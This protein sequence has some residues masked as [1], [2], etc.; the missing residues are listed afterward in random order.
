VQ[1]YYFRVVTSEN[2]LQLKTEIYHKKNS[3]FY[4]RKIN[5]PIKWKSVKYL[6]TGQIKIIHYNINIYNWFCV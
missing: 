1:I 5:L 6:E 2:F 3:S 4:Y